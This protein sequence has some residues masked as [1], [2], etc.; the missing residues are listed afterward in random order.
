MPLITF[1]RSLEKAGFFSPLAGMEY[2]EQTVEVR[3]DP[4]TGVTALDS[5]E[6]ATKQRMFV[7]A[8]DWEFS[9]ELGRRSRETCFFCP[10]KVLHATPRYPDGVVDGGRLQYGSVLVFPNLFPLAGVHAVGTCP[11]RHFLRPS[12]FSADLLADWFGAAVEFAGRAERAYAGLEHLEVC[13]NH[14]LMA[15]ASV[16]HPHFQ[17]LAGA[18]P[19]GQVRALWDGAAAFRRRHTV[20]YWRALA[21]EE[22][23]RGERFVAAAAGCTWLTSFAPAGNREVIAV[24][25]DVARVA[26]LNADHVR[27]LAFGLSRVLAWYETQEICAF[28]FALSGGPLSGADGAHAV[29]LR[30]VARFAYQPDHRSDQYFL[31]KQLGAELIFARPEEMAAELRAAFGRD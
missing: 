8:S 19:P 24:V 3:R 1:E 13:C 25:P 15:G 30:V 10:E 17:L 11:D 7:A 23:A 14:M 29:V 2:A 6:L 12:Q 28:N 22:S 4:L 27:M 9:E 5:S 31:Q 16:I 20:S 18:T 21:D 26:Q